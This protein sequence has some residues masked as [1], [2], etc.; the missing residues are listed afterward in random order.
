[1]V[2]EKRK[3]QNEKPTRGTCLDNPD[4]V[5]AGRWVTGRLRFTLSPKTRLWWRGLELSLKDIEHAIVTEDGDSKEAQSILIQNTY[6]LASWD[7]YQAADC[8][9]RTQTFEYP[10]RFHLPEDLP[11]T[12]IFHTTGEEGQYSVHYELTAFLVATKQGS[13]VRSAV[14]QIRL[15]LLA[16]PWLRRGNYSSRES[17]RIKASGVL[18]RKQTYPITTRLFRRQGNLEVGYKLHTNVIM[19][20]DKLQIGFFGMNNCQDNIGIKSLCRVER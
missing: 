14:Q 1:M 9:R 17:H 4:N 15:R 18:V 7:Y 2:Y 11:G 12:V 10:F 5:V 13:L 19:P 3:E 16:Q 8:T 20:G 6:S